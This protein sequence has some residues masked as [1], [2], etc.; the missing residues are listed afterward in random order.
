MIA[1][2]LLLDV[3]INEERV[4]LGVDVLHHDLE[5]VKASSLRD[6]DLVGES[7]K[8]VLVDNSVRC[9]EK[10]ENVGN[11]IALIIVESIVPIVEILG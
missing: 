4:C 7:L 3:G 2:C 9:G 10:G 8:E 1:L 6:L 5:A 11:E